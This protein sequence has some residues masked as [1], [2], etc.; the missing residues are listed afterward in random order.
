MATEFISTTIHINGYFLTILPEYRY[1]IA[2]CDINN[3]VASA[4]GF[5]DYKTAR[6]AGVAALDAKLSGIGAEL[7]TIGD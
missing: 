6:N 3:V 4:D 2:Q 5:I 7:G 1:T